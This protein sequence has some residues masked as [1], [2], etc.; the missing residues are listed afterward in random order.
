RKHHEPRPGQ[1]APAGGLLPRQ[2][3]PA[4]L[5]MNCFETQQMKGTMRK[6][7]LL[8]ALSVFSPALLF[9]QGDLN[10]AGPPGPT[11]RTLQQVE[12]RTPISSLP[13]NITNG[14]AYYLTGN[15]SG[16]VGITISTSDVDLDLMGFTLA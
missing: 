6:F 12:P 14:G 1:F 15:L 10:P 2:G 3:R 8:T 7:V 13:F 11:M 5:A 9:G 16:S 4:A